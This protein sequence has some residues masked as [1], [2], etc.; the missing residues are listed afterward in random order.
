MGEIK[1]CVADMAKDSGGLPQSLIPKKGTLGGLRMELK[2]ELSSLKKEPAR[3]EKNQDAILA[4]VEKL[5]GS[6][7][8]TPFTHCSLKRSVWPLHMM[9]S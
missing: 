6:C 5:P 3:L 8:S 4:A 7:L 2:G 1:A 9:L